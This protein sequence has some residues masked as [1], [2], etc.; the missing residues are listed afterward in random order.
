M[1]EETKK[2]FKL[3]ASYESIL[4]D[5]DSVQKWLKVIIRIQE[6]DPD[7]KDSTVL[8]GLFIAILITY[9]RCF[10]SGKREILQPEEIYNGLKGDPLGLHRYLI[11]MR[12]KHIAHSVNSFEQI[13][14]GVFISDKKEIFALGKLHSKLI[15]LS[16]KDFQQIFWLESEAKKFVI[17]EGI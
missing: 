5:L 16:K 6:N 10:T 1:E 3:I 11:D 14:I 8:S 17:S 12:N 2:Q 13:Q 7:L 9:A 15:A 4:T